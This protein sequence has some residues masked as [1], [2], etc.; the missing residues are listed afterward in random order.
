MDQANAESS[1]LNASHRAKGCGAEKKIAA[2]HHGRTGAVPV[3]QRR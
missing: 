2:T 3:L 1:S